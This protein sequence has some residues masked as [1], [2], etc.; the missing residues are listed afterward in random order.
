MSQLSKRVQEITLNS[1]PGRPT[2]KNQGSPLVNHSKS[3]RNSI[4]S[5]NSSTSTPTNPKVD[6]NT[7][8]S[9]LVSMAGW[10]GQKNTTNNH[11]TM[12][13]ASS[14]FS[15]YSN[16]TADTMKEIMENFAQLPQSEQQDIRDAFQFL[17]L[18]RDNKV[19]K[20]ELQS[21]FKTVMNENLSISEC[22]AIFEV[23]DEDGS[24]F[25][26]FDEFVELMTGEVG[27]KSSEM[28]KSNFTN[29]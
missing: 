19:D 20:E 22:M 5:K 12:R 7:K 13:R 10:K 27:R 17:D 21:V 23:V 28:Y 4:S 11:F 18:K 24:G 29:M 9:T 16:S 3:R 14:S 1:G 26:D 8:T 6:T 25:I 15:F 2:I